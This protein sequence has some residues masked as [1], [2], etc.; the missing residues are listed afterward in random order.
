M[1]QHVSQSVP[2]Q[3]QGEA[4]EGTKSWN[5][6]TLLTWI[7]A[8]VLG[9]LCAGVLLLIS[10]EPLS[11][12]L[13]ILGITLGVA[14]LPIA[15]YFPQLIEQGVL[16][17][18]AATL[19]ISLKKHL[20]YQAGHMGGAIGL[21]VSITAILALILL[22][23]LA[24]RLR[25]NRKIQITVE[26]PLLVAFLVYLGVATLSTAFGSDFKLGIF[27]LSEIVQSFLLF[28]LLR[29]Y[30]VD[31]RRY[32]LFVT[33]LLAGLVLQSAVAL[34]QVERPGLLNLTFLG[35]GEQEPVEVNGEM[36]IPDTDV[37][38]IMLQGKV[39]ERPTGLLIHPNV[40]AI[41][42][43]L[44]IP[45]S[46]ASALVSRFSWLQ[47]LGA[48]GVGLSAPALYFTLSRSGWT[49]LAAALALAAILWLLWKPFKLSF[50]KRILLAVITV[51]VA[52]GIALRAN[53]IYERWI[54]TFNES[55]T[56]RLS[57]ANTAWHMAKAY[58][59]LGVGL[60]SFETVVQ[61]FDESTESRL[62]PFAV[63]NILLLELS[64]T[65]MLGAAIFVVFWFI[66]F[67][68]MIASVRRAK[69]PFAR[70]VGLFSICGLL[71]FFLAD[72][73]GF[74]YR[75]PIVTSMVW[76]QVALALCAGE[77]GGSVPGDVCDAAGMARAPSDGRY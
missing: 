77:I 33:G 22:A 61:Q 49:G 66:T 27:Q 14:C 44:I 37:G 45:V 54:E 24:L 75:I 26:K 74:S 68:C 58:P 5:A 30:L 1:L 70:V 31:Q 72:M 53:R 18:L 9:I 29:N 76:V 35:A 60:N 32:K 41:Y 46:I 23:V 8:G 34:V 11:I 15:G 47:A 50:S 64:E 73:T 39:Q 59:F 51:V 71:G 10:S 6:G 67:R 13:V 55:V 7:S 19:S 62:K 17:T 43:V 65:G 69:I 21:R 16:F 63:H 2:L 3:E 56:F 57:L 48:L 52:C 25:K 40:L 12:A 42:F 20:I 36:I 38:T 28:L 4:R